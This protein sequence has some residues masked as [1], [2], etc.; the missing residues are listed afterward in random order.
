MV[1]TVGVASV[2]GSVVTSV[3]GSVVAS[4]VGSVVASE[5]VSGRVL[6]SRVS[7]VVSNDDEVPEQ[8]KTEHL[9]LV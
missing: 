2:V 7:L 4:V 3:V 6:L 9:V 8:V 1:E 5:E